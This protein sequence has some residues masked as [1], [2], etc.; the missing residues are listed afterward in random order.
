MFGW[1]L[2]GKWERI[3]KEPVVNWLNYC[4]SI[5]HE[6]VKKTTDSLSEDIQI[7]TQHLQ[8]ASLHQPGSAQL[9][10]RMFK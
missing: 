8:D 6:V 7:R 10:G 9:G 4:P 5:C 3:W 1:Y 2:N